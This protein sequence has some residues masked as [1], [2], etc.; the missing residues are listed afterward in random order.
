[1]RTGLLVS[2]ALP[3]L[4]QDSALAELN[5]G[6]NDL[7]VRVVD[8]GPGLCAVVKVPDRHYMV[9]DTGHW[10]QN[11]LCV[12]AAE[13]IIGGD[14]IDLM[15]ISHSDGDH[16]ADGDDILNKFTVR[17]IIR[18]GFRRE[19][20]TGWKT[21]NNAIGD[22]A[23][24]DATVI[25]LQTTTLVPGTRLAIGPATLTLVFGLGQWTATPLG[26]SESRNAIS[27]VVRLEYQG[28]AVLFAGDTV[29][30]RIGAP[31]S[32]CDDAEALMVA[33]HNDAGIGRVPLDAEVIIAPHHGADNAS[34]TCFI[35]AVNP[36]SVV[37]PAGHAFQHPRKD[38]A[39]RYLDH[40][41]A[42]SNMFRTDRGDDEGSQEWSFGRIAGC[43]DKKGDDDVEIVI[44][45]DGTVSVD[46]RQPQSGC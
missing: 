22:E 6:P 45:E 4:L 36:S 17:Q 15:I 31:S 26:E 18:T 29:G 34:S 3:L 42:E 46:Y 32:A 28:S 27:I 43:Q 10:Q 7:Y 9:Y 37:F 44:A 25:N 24:Q 39:Q 40:G 8:N 16:I 38:A 30:R 11:H 13:E 35:A 1:M 5:P 41:V 23:K 20:T 14:P 12:N 19:D 33:N 2:L 21:L